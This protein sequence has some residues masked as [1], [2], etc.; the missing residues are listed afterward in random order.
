MRGFGKISKILLGAA[1]I[2]AIASASQAADAVIPEVV[3]TG[4]N[5][6]GFYIGVGGGFGAV[7]HGISSPLLPDGSFNGIGGEGIFGELTVGYD[8]M[9]GSRFVVGAFVD[10]HIGNIGPE[11]D[12]NIGGVD[13]FDASIENSYGFD[14]GVRAGF[15][16]NPTTLA[17]V[18]G[19]YAWQHFDLNTNFPGVESDWDQDG[20]FVGF[21]ME[22]VIHGNWTL[23]TEYRYTD[24][25]SQGFF[26]QPRIGDLLKIDPTTHTFHIAANYRFGA[27]G[28]AETFAPP[29]YNW[30]GFYIG[31]AGGAGAVVHDVNVDLFPPVPFLSAGLNGIGGEGI[32]GELS[33]GYDHDFGNFVAGVFADGRLS[34]ISTELDLGAAFGGAEANI[35]DE[36]GFDIGVRAGMKLNEV[37]LAYVLAAYTWE[38]FDINVSGFGPGIDGSLYD[39]DA[40]GFTV[41]G[42]LEAAM[43]DKLSLNVEY[44]YTQLEDED[45]SSALGAP[46]GTLTAEPSFHTVRFGA[47]WK[48]NVGG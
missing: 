45:F 42:G 17:Y 46:A 9:F 38:H 15:L 6:S 14:A 18:L 3:P 27:E 7:N 36:H 25:G 39:W 8:H 48:F 5:W 13:V 30:S 11:L 29:V 4:F 19:G 31:A 35:D 22:S 24:L 23:K 28:G 21:G 34:G 40:G 43:T 26:P 2:A 47:K 20:Y 41:G 33:V 32:F 1:S 37:T 10:G 44:R 16:V 12:I